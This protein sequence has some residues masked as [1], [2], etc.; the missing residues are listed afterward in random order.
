[1]RSILPGLA[2]SR[3]PTEKAITFL[4]LRSS[5]ETAFCGWECKSVALTSSQ[6]TKMGICDSHC[7]PLFLKLPHEHPVSCINAQVFQIW[8]QWKSRDDPAARSGT[9]HLL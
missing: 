4:T 3:Q 1:M 7:E 5:H 2:K 9:Q 6:T 8:Y